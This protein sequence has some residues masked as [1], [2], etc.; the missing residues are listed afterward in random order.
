M[1]AKKNVLSRFAHFAGLRADD[2]AP[3]T[4]VDKVNDKVEDLADDQDD[5]TDDVKSVEDRLDACESRLDALEADD[6]NSDDEDMADDDTPADDDK[7]PE[8][9]KLSRFQAG[10]IAERARAAAIFADPAASANPVLAS[11]LAFNSGLSAAKA[12]A[13]LKASATPAPKT[14]LAAK[15]ANVPAINIKPEAAGSNEPLKPHQRLAAAAARFNG[16]K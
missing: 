6:E 16:S 9:K 2:D 10:R 14:S 1:A 11:E 3:A 5:I 12:V 4:D 7:K 8:A 13:L 15:M